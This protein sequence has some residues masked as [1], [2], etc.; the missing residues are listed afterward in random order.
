MQRSIQQQHLYSMKKLIVTVLSFSFFTMASSQQSWTIR[1]D[2]KTVLKKVTE[3]R[4]KNVF[5]LNKSSVSG[6][7]KLIIQLHTIDTANHI[8]L[9]A[10][11]DTDNIVKEWEYSDKTLSIPVG[12]L[13]T[14]W[15]AESKL[16]FYYRSLPKDP[17]KAAV[18]RIRPV[19]IC[20]ILLK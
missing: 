10:T 4:V 14:L 19:H 15:G 1:L 13:K 11:L 18:V 3:D 8:T 12:E 7:S 2:K 9:M 5:T 17:E 16:H 20:T 6:N